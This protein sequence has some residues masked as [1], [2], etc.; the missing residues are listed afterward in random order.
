MAK[1]T[2]VPFLLET[3]L[4]ELGAQVE[5]VENWHAHAVTD[6]KLVTGEG[7]G[8]GMES[9]SQ[10]RGAGGGGGGEEGGRGGCR[11]RG[12]GGG[13]GGPCAMGQCFFL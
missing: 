12:A 1:E 8:V 6:G 4:K 9:W 2:L 11:T 13:G 3:K 7:G 10:V 5:V